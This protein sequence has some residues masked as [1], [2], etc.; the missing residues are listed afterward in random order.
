[1]RGCFPARVAERLIDGI[2]A[3][4]NKALVKAMARVQPQV[5]INC[6]GVIKQVKGAD[7]PLFAIPVNGVLPHRLARLCKPAMARLIHISTDCVFSGDKG[8]YT[9]TDVPDAVDLYGRSKCM[10]EVHQPHTIT[11]RTSFI[12]H[13]LRGQHS[14]LGWF[15]SRRGRCRGFTRAV[16]SGLPAVV[17]AQI[18]RDVIIPRADLY[19]LYHVASEPISKFDLLQLVARV[20]GKTIE[21]DRQDSPVIDRSLDA[22]RF[23]AASGYSPP[24][25]PE[26][27]NVMHAYYRE[28]ANR[29]DVQR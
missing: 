23:R 7:N 18:V 22:R 15:L 9:E 4:D 26:L 8:N 3:L 29:K 2:D 20:Y 19:G 12:G 17:L 21:V 28:R 1:V 27:V 10:G 5:V 6:I 13:E 11:L 14:L 24:D 25:W 16:F